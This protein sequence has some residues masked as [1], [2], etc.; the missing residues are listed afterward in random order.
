MLGDTELGDLLNF[1]K[2]CSLS[3]EDVRLSIA[4]YGG[5]EDGGV[6]R[7][8][9]AAKKAQETKA[10]QRRNIGKL[11]GISSSQGQ[12]GAQGFLPPPQQSAALGG[13][14]GPFGSGALR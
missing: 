4:R 3:P 14:A 1:L 8:Y 6:G 7:R 12:A 13:K 10:S 2:H 9:D 11:F 5:G